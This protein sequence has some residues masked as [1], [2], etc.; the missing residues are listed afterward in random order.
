L[1]NRDVT[2]VIPCFNYGRYLPEAV[3]SALEQEGGAPAVVVVDDGSTDEDTLRVLEELPPG[4]ELLRQA[5][6]GVCRARNAGLERVATPYALVLDADDR[7]APGALAALTPPLDADPRLGFAYGRIQ[8]FGDWEGEMRF[9]DYD[10]F[11]LLYRHTIGPSALARIEVF[12]DTGGYDPAFPELEDWEL[13]LNALE[14]GWRGRRVDAV[15]HEYRR[16]G[17]GKHTEDRRGYRVFW[18]RLRHKHAALYERRD[19]LYAE[20]GLGRT[21]R[22][23]HELYWG[24]RPVPARVEQ[25]LYGLR[26]RRT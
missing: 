16:H 9:G 25:A 24:P 4:V 18:R 3:S 21:G 14:H 23:V 10:P 7:L 17:H 5:N 13:W 19:E 15:T 12:R 26:W 20:S 11:V 6:A 2:V 22:L 8:F 1:S